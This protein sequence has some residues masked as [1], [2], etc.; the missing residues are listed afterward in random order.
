M[1]NKSIYLAF[2]IIFT[3]FS[4]DKKNE[5]D[6]I[7]NVQPEFKYKHGDIISILGTGFGTIPNFAFS[8]G[9]S[10]RIEKKAI[11][12]DNSILDGF[13]LSDGRP[14]YVENDP[15]RGKVWKSII[16]DNNS[17]TADDGV[18]YHDWGSQIPSGSKIF[19]HWFVKA[20]NDAPII[21]W[22]MWRQE[23]IQSFVDGG[24]QDPNPEIT[25]FNWFGAGDKSISVRPNILAGST[26]DVM[27]YTDNAFPDLDNKW[28]SIEVYQKLSDSG[29]HDGSLYWQIIKNGVKSAIDKENIMHFNTNVTQRPR[30]QVWQNYY[31]YPGSVSTKSNVWMDDLYVQVA[32]PSSPLVRVYLCDTN[33][34]E[35]STKREIQK[36]VN[37]WTNTAATIELNK[38][39]FSSGT[40]YL[41]VVEG[42]NTQLAYKEIAVL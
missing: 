40:Y 15:I 38:G 19:L 17:Q 33:N 11:G 6:P 39:G 22:K 37:G 14:K 26:E 42:K 12:L 4:C 8:G 1:K 41:I 31:G 18:I 23:V 16:S 28:S 13:D 9:L 30:W 21:Q 34:F 2:L 35:T 10:G 3:I 24:S 5:E 25:V 7:P 29:V 32:S 27:F 20:E 36:P